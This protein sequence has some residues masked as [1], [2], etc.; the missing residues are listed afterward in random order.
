[1]RENYV[2]YRRSDDISISVLIPTRNYV[3][4]L[5][6][7]TRVKLRRSIYYVL[8]DINTIHRG[9]ILSGR[10]SSRAWRAPGVSRQA[11]VIVV[12]VVVVAR[13][14]NLQ[15]G[16]SHAL[17]IFSVASAYKY[18]YDFSRKKK[19]CNASSSFKF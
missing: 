12:V 14:R 15:H 18:I 3:S 11:K 8:G 9:C 1:M 2:R 16:V 5:L 6:Y 13:R 7:K 17:A 4:F 10:V 19:I